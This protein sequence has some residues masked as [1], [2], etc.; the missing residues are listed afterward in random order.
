MTPNEEAELHLGP[1]PAPVVSH[2][3]SLTTGATPSRKVHSMT[4]HY[5]EAGR[6][7][8]QAYGEARGDQN[9]VVLAQIS[10]TYAILALVDALENRQ[11]NVTD[12]LQLRDEETRLLAAD[13]LALARKGETL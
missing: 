9:A 5:S 12:L 13:L 4:S 11:I 2:T 1:S 7:A 3:L 10:T 8:D 6:R